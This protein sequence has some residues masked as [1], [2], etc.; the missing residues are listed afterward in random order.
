MMSAMARRGPGRTGRRRLVLL[1]ALAAVGLLAVCCTS[2]GDGQA[3]PET[4]TEA[5]AP[6]RPTTTVPPV[7]TPQILATITPERL[8][9]SNIVRLTAVVT[10]C[11]GLAE[12]CPKDEQGPVFVTMYCEDE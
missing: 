7:A 2:G 5:S 10:G 9:R 4:T 12:T 11:T 6:P 1:G 8:G 3:L